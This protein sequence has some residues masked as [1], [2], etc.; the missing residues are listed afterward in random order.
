MSKHVL[1]ERQNFESRKRT[2]DF[3]RFSTELHEHGSKHVTGN[4]PPET[5][6]EAMDNDTKDH[7]PYQQRGDPAAEPENAVTERMDEAIY[8]DHFVPTLSTLQPL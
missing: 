3:N 7:G 2:S 8:C 6:D 1:T 5:M 4:V